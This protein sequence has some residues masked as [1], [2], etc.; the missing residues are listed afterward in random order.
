MDTNPNMN[1]VELET[2]RTLDTANRID[3]V[4]P[5]N[6]LMNRL[7]QIP[8]QVKQGY[9]AIPKRVVWAAAASIAVLIA[10]NILF[11]KNYSES[12]QETP[13]SSANSYFDHLK[14]L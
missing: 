13:N 5:S 12:R 2:E 8:A 11:A 14:T 9:D 7:K 4:L 3:S 6:D 1:K 10:I